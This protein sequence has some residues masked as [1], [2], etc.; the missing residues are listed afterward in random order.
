MNLTFLPIVLLQFVLT[1]LPFTGICQTID[2]RRYHASSPANEIN[3]YQLQSDS[4]FG[5]KQAV[6]IAELKWVEH[7][8]LKIGI[9]YT[10]SSLKKTSILAEEAKA[11]VALN[12]GFFDIEKGGSVAY[13]ESEGRVISQ[14]RSANE[15][16]GKS[17]SL[18]NGAV[19]LDKSGSLGLE[20]A[21][22][23][24]YYESSDKERAV[25]VTGPLLLIEGKSLLLENSSFV[26]NRHPRS[27]LCETNTKD[28]LFIAIDG[29]S[30][31]ASGM[32]LKEVQEFLLR[33]NC[34]NAINLDGGGSTTL[35][36]NDG[37]QKRII[38]HPSDKSGERPVANILVIK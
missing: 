20:M 21:K 27:C 9:V 14:T 26:T 34:K 23:P 17:D 36:V 8:R 35:W 33:L 22:S 32:N 24:A 16:W 5:D 12:G 10:A 19:I 7:S 18:L 30:E 4:I 29:R 38:N 28:I 6:S 3:T 2:L 11:I 37:I 25:M 13:L 31:T 1:I 15:K